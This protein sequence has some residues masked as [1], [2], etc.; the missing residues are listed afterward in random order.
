MTQ[1]PILYIGLAQ[2]LF[3]AF[4]L[5]TKATVAI[6][7]RILIACLLTIALKFVVLVLH[8]AHSDFFDLDFSMAIIPLTFGPFLYL[9]TKYLVGDE[10]RFRWGDLLHFL[11]FVIATA[12]YFVFL[13][14]IVS[15]EVVDYFRPDAY[16][17]VRIIF[18]LVFFSSVL[19]YTVLT[20]TRLRAFRSSLP[21][22]FSY[23]SERLRLH[24]LSFVAILF[25]LI[26]VVY[27]ALGIVN[28]LTFSPVFDI[29]T[30]SHIGLTILAYSVSYFGLRQPLLF[31]VVVDP[32]ETTGPVAPSIE[33]RSRNGRRPR[34]AEERA[35]E[36]TETLLSHMREDKPFLNSELTASDLSR[37]INVPK[38][39]L[40]FLLNDHLG[41]NFF[42]F[43][44]EYRLEEARRRLRDPRYSHL[45][46]MAIAVDS[47]FSSKSSFN[48]LFKQD[49]GLTPSEYRKR[50]NDS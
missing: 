21:A 36:L 42:S 8:T 38:Q 6:S 18:G 10:M 25:S 31:P 48:S 32:D 13:K 4:V 37:R 5:A 12:I 33:E 35:T 17:A 19:I 30:L 28:A 47:G 45:T 41:K 46:I 2:S 44:N 50:N 7:D 20:V 3:A 14:D 1:D 29:V 49:T 27:F 43:V 26:F 16:L 11:P 34:L 23:T 9:Y 39:E 15:F 22:E 24:W 40:T